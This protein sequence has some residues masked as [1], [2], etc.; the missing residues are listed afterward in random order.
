M[1]ILDITWQAYRLPFTGPFSTAHGTLAVREGAIVTLTTTQGIT[2]IG[3]I[4]P[5]PGLSKETLAEALAALHIVIPHLRGLTLEDALDVLERERELLP[6][7]TSCGVEMALYDV[8]ARCIAPVWA[9]TDVIH[10]ATTSGNV[11]SINRFPT[12]AV[13]AVIGVRSTVNAVEAAIQAKRDGFSCV[14]LKVGVCEDAR[15]E[16]A[17]IAAV[18]A[19]LGPDIALRL[20]ANEAWT[21]EQART[22][23]TALSEC[24]PYTIEYVEQPLP[25]HDIDGMRRLRTTVDIALAA[26]EAVHDMQ[27]TRA[28]MER[29]AAD[30]LI[31]KPQLTGGLRACQRIVDEATRHGIA[32]VLTTTIE[33]GVSLAATLQLAASLPQITLACGFGTLSLLV[34][35]LINEPLPIKNGLMNVPT[36]PG[37][38]VTLD[39]AAMQRYGNGNGVLR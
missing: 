28:V 26:D 6:P 29:E 23:L 9:M 17:R 20:D 10:H 13:N 1:L 24:N 18:R 39:E 31:L 11:E 21:F 5:F 12:I 35:D 3:E 7:S 33:S 27:S 22:V 14:K 8:V 32:C 38:G 16:I 30:V 25:A 34:D 19:T 36:G 37:W 15:Q 4:A 2:G